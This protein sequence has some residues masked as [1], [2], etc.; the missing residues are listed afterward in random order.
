[1]TRLVRRP[2]GSVASD[3]SGKAAGR[4]TYVCADPSCHEPARLADGVR[5]TLGVSMTS[6]IMVNEVSHATT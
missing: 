3:A 5:R 1:M 4:G 6:E 2:D